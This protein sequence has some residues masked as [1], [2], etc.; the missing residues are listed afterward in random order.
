MLTALA[1]WLIASPVFALMC[2]KAIHIRDTKET[3]K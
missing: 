1:L 2:G 3:L